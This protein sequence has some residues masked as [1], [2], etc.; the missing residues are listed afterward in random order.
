MLANRLL[1]YRKNVKA[2]VR[3][4]TRITQFQINLK[5][6]GGGSRR[7]C[8]EIK[9]IFKPYLFLGKTRKGTRRKT[10]PA[11]PIAKQSNEQCFHNDA[12]DMAIASNARFNSCRLPLP[13]AGI[14][15][16]SQSAPLSKILRGKHK[17]GNFP[18]ADVEQR[19]EHP[20]TKPQPANIRTEPGPKRHD[21]AEEEEEEESHEGEETPPETGRNPPD[22]RV[23][24]LDAVLLPGVPHGVSRK[25]TAR[26]A[27]SRPHVRKAVRM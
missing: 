3:I 5:F 26:A 9:N 8:N 27:P 25:G 23:G 14:N 11:K 22:D 20:G 17:K 2:T 10:T 18:T 15:A 16:T 13:L 4:R 21:S 19:S 1:M 12:I 7:D 6:G 24:R